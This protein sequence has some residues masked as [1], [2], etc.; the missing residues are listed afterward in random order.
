MPTKQYTK[1]GKSCRVTFRLPA[2]VKSK[3]IHLC[4]DFNEWNPKAHPMKKKLDGSHYAI[5]YLDTGSSYQYKFKLAN[6][7]WEND[8][9]AEAY[10]KNA[11]GEDD[12]VITV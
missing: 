10:V 1:T 9:E 2:A 11:Y 6:G 8:W 3:K 4:G 7:K 12:S 5:V